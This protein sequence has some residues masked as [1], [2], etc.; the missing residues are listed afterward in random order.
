LSRIDRAFLLRYIFLRFKK[1]RVG[2]ISNWA[3]GKANVPGSQEY[4]ELVVRFEH[5]SKNTEQHY[6]SREIQ[7][8][9]LQIGWEFKRRKSRRRSGRK[10]WSRRRRLV[11]SAP[12]DVLCASKLLEKK[13]K[14]LL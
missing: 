9:G 4:S 14:N 8:A 5:T 12:D 10:S 6:E 2:A 1:N 13:Q 7:A 11:V 3:E